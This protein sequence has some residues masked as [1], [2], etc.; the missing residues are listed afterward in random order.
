MSA[1]ALTDNVQDVEH[2]PLFV[3]PGTVFPFEALTVDMRT[4]SNMAFAGMIAGGESH[5]E[6]SQRKFGIATSARAP[7]GVV[8]VL[9]KSKPQLV[10][11]GSALRM[12]VTC[13]YRYELVGKLSEEVED[14]YDANA[15]ACPL[16]WSV[17]NGFPCIAIRRLLD[18]ARPL[19]P[20]FTS[21]QDAF[22]FISSPIIQEKTTHRALTR[23]SYCPRMARRSRSSIILGLPFHAWHA[24][25]EDSLLQRIRI[26]AAT[27]PSMYRLAI[28]D[29]LVQTVPS[30]I[31]SAKG[32]PARWSFWFASA[33]DAPEAEKAELLA[34]TI[35]AIR[36]KRILHL[37]LQPESK[38]MARRSL[39]KPAK[40]SRVERQ[41]SVLKRQRVTKGAAVCTPAVFPLRPLPVFDVATFSRARTSRQ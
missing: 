16:Q 41:V 9:D 27:P 5:T 19:L 39:K 4:G 2:I 20:L 30:G 32:A 11:A 6:V 28:D 12:H 40:R 34:E 10:W 8:A 29:N 7:V 21:E 37:L 3:L 18:V 15:C 23:S 22:P 14:A 36:L 31:D 38:S 13:I 1:S 24:L 25:L 33:L 17:R 26:L 35:P